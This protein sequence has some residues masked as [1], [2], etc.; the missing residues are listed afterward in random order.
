MK[1]SEM[2]EV[3]LEELGILYNASPGERSIKKLK[4]LFKKFKEF[5]FDKDRIADY[6]DFCF[7]RMKKVV[8]EKEK[9]S[10]VDYFVAIVA[11]EKTFKQYLDFVRI[12]GE[13]R[14]ENP[15]AES[16]EPEE[17]EIKINGHRYIKILS[18]PDREIFFCPDVI[19]FLIK[20]YS[21]MVPKF[22]RLAQYNR[23]HPDKEITMNTIKE[24]IKNSSN[25]WGMDYAI[26]REKS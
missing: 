24:F 4:G 5:K 25:W 12:K 8:K 7:K 16:Q 11:S 23:K 9:K 22:Y 13:V 1:Q 18:D 19:K 21:D 17:E 2:I 6:I 26:R 15:I 20:D 3:M 14:E 10:S